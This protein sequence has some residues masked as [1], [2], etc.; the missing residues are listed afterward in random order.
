MET[1]TRFNQAKGA[2]WSLPVLM[3]F[4]A[5]S[6]GGFAVGFLIW[7][8][9]WFAGWTGVLLRG[10]LPERLRLLRSPRAA[11]AD[12]GWR[13]TWVGLLMLLAVCINPSGPVMLLYPFKTVSIGA[14]QEIFR[15]G[16]RLIFTP[17]TEQPFIR[18]RR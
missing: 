11:L 15:N 4:W 18:L 14:L 10:E 16:S 3:L 8:I 7:G 6:H 9:Y 5:N 17:A 12:P 2:S 13:L 1:K